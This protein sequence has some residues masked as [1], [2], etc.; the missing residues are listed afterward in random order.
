[1]FVFQRQKRILK[2]CTCYNHF[3]CQNQFLRSQLSLA[4]LLK[5]AEVSVQWTYSLT[6]LLRLKPPWVLFSSQRSLSVCLCTMCHNLQLILRSVGTKKHLGP[7]L[8]FSFTCLQSPRQPNGCYKKERWCSSC[9]P[10]SVRLVPVH[11]R[12][13]EHHHAPSCKTFS[14]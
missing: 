8:I 12:T 13:H 7:H 3:F 2:V 4:E 14:L 5:Q 6:S 1:M 10:S 11:E 9:R